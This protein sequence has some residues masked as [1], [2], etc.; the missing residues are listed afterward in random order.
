VLTS[1]FR[2]HS[3]LGAGPGPGLAFICLASGTADLATLCLNASLPLT[4]LSD[5]GALALPEA[6]R[7]RD[8]L[9]GCAFFCAPHM[10]T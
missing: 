8:S 7:L 1:A 9:L 6:E 10:H 2:V 3:F 5:G 4:G